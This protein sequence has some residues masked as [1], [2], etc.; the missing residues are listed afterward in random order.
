MGALG[1][2]PKRLETPPQHHRPVSPSFLEDTIN[3]QSVAREN[4]LPPALVD[5]LENRHLDQTRLVLQGD[6][7]HR[8]AALGGWA[9]PGDD[10]PRDSHLSAVRQGVKL[11]TQ[12]NPYLP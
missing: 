1:S 5:A 6:E 12:H 8:L 3:D 7:D 9:L 2:G 10:D 11:G 4:D